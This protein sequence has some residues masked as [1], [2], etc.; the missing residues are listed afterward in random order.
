MAENPPLPSLSCQPA[1]WL[2]RQAVT[3]SE[4]RSTTCHGQREAAPPG[5]RSIVAMPP[6]E[7]AARRRPA[8][9]PPVCF[10]PQSISVSPPAPVLT[11]IRSRALARAI[12]SAIAP[13]S[14]LRLNEPMFGVLLAPTAVN[15]AGGA[16]RIN[17]H[18]ENGERTCSGA[19]ILEPSLRPIDSAAT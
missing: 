6:S 15:L 10:A 13:P 18:A 9:I 11:P 19:D 12:S 14:A 4:L 8:S 3:G 5:T 1:Y 2:P 17:D 7:T 16:T